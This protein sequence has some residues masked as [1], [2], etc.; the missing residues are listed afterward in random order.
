V[1]VLTLAACSD[2]T[3]GT[4]DAGTVDVRVRPPP[5][6]RQW[7]ECQPGQ[8]RCYQNI[9]QTCSAAGELTQVIEDECIPRGMVCDDALWCVICR[10]G[11]LRCTEN[12]LS[13][14]RC[15]A[16]GTGYEPVRDCDTSRG[17]A[18]RR[19]QCVVLCTDDSV[20][21][22]NIGCE[23]YGVDLDN[24]VETGGRSAASQQYAIVV[25]NPDPVLTVRIEVSRNTAPQG[26]PP[27]LERLETRVIPPRDLEVLELPSREVDCSTVAGLNDG[28]GTC[29]SS[30][31]YRVTSN[32]PVIAYQFNPLSN[33]GVF[34]NDASLL[35]PSN[36]L[37]GTYRFLGYPQQWS[38][39]TNPD[40]NGGEEIRSFMTIVG[41]QANT[42][43]RV[44]PTADII[45]GGPFRERHPA[46]TPF[47]VVI[48]AFDVLN[49]ETGAFL[50]DFTGS[51]INADGPVAVF[52]GTE[53]TDVP[54]WRTTA[55]RQPACDHIEEQLFPSST[56]GQ[57]YVASRTP[58]RTRAV[59]LAGASV[60]EVNEPEWFRVLNV[61]S[62]IVH[63]TTTLP[64]D[65]S[66]PAGPKVEFDLE[67]GGYHDIRAL[68]DF[69]VR[70]DA[71]VSVGQLQGSQTTTGI[72]LTLPGGDPALII[73]PPVEQWRTDYVFL[74]PNKYAFDFVQIVARPDVQVFLDETDV[75]DFS[76]CTRSRSDG[77]VESRTNQCPPPVYVTYRCQLSFPRID[78]SVM[79]PAIT[80]G[81]Q[82]DGVHV[83][84]S[85]TPSTRPAEGVMVLVSGFDR[86]VSYAYAGGTNLV[87]VR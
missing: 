18:C 27:V 84:R 79:P 56:A 35:V 76:D 20:A 6:P 55:E 42:R 73:V 52:A 23:Y 16:T 14:E 3:R 80:A 50:A 59:N 28:T 12:S 72:P 81:R 70:A 8:Q 13:V 40:T 19:G 17:E 46:G 71:P 15:N 64:E 43:V 24:I 53:C 29:L 41:T 87:P 69:I 21:H 86:F 30:R 9:H 26:M 31:A 44:T 36:S 1:L 77:C 78:N 11:E 49:L 85:V 74:T 22:S 66:M 61:S 10:P 68:A 48:G 5:D 7:I 33:V 32:Y 47:D 38:R 60:A 67:E 62:R 58:T 82:G 75:S 39:T 45:P 25:S 54:F 34:S 37:E 2:T 4:E 63:V 51:L 65:I 83:V 57:N